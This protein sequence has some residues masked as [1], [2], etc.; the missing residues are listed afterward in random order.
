MNRGSDNDPSQHPN[1]DINRTQ[2]VPLI[3]T[4]DELDPDVMTSM[5]SLGCFKERDSLGKY[6]IISLKGQGSGEK[7][8]QVTIKRHN[9]KKTFDFQ[10]TGKFLPAH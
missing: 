2:P 6:T 10:N 5:S 8:G 3:G 1:P 4:E 9:C 7:F